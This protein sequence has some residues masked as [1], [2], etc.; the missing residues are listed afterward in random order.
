MKLRAMQL[1]RK[2][3]MHG[4][5][6]ARI[7]VL[8]IIPCSNHVSEFHSDKGGRFS[9][10]VQGGDVPRNLYLLMIPTARYHKSRCFLFSIYPCLLFFPLEAGEARAIG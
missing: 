10:F 9:G 7:D 6:I 1:R 8:V 3:L 2:M 5:G 4:I